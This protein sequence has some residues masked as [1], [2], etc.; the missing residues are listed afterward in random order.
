[1]MDTTIPAELLDLK[2]RLDHWRATNR[3]HLRQP[4]PPDLRQ[5]VIA[6]SRRY[7]GTILRR[8]L[9][10]DPWRLN[11]STAKKPRHGATHKKERTTFFKLPTDAILPD[12]PSA[13][14]SATDCRLQFERPDGARLT[15]TLPNLD[16]VSIHRLADLFLR[17][18][19]Q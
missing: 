4:L 9:N 8:V 1:M 12:L 5:E 2:T 6:I 3:K 18:D 13:P 10:I 14:I 16:L 11:R 7:P 17:G 15:L 19:K